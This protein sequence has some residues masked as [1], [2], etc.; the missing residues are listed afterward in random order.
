MEIR[1]RQKSSIETPYRGSSVGRGGEGNQKT[2]VVTGT[3]RKNTSGRKKGGMADIHENM[4]NPCVHRRGVAGNLME[5]VINGGRASQGSIRERNKNRKQ[6]GPGLGVVRRSRG[7][8]IPDSI[9]VRVPITN[10]EV[11]VRKEGVLARETVKKPNSNMACGGGIDIGKLKD[12][13][14]EAKAGS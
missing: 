13:P 14:L 1:R 3:E 5:S 8:A 11:K 7:A 9:R 6:T 4:I 2:I 10:Q 12:L